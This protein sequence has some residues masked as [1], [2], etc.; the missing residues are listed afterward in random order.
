MTWTTK[1]IGLGACLAVLLSSAA[2]MATWAAPPRLLT[3]DGHSDLNGV[4][5]NA[6]IT[7]LNRP[8]N[9]PLV[10]T[11]EQAKT[12][13][14]TS[15]NVKRSQA[16]AKPSNL[17]P[18]LAPDRNTEQ[19]YNA[20][21][22]DPGMSMGR[23]KDEYRTSWIV[24]P[25]DGQ[26]PLTDKGR[27]QAKVGPARSRAA[28]AGPEAMA[29]NDRCLIGSRGSGGPGMLNNLYNNTYQI[30]QTPD[31][32]AIEV[33]M[34]HDVRIIPL[35]AS[36][37]LAQAGHRPAVMHPWLGDS[38]GWWE[39]AV[40]VVETTNVN[41]EQGENGPIFLSPQGLVTERFQRW[42]TG[43]IFYSFEVSDPL[44]YTGPWKAEMGL[45]AIPGQL[46]EYACHEGNYA[47]EGML[48]GAR[49]E[50]KLRAAKAP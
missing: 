39:G 28:P 23:V 40:L 10:L 44:Y 27:A 41:P 19:G 9:T 31:A 37:A 3:A 21:W 4:W 43:Q 1:T 26:L 12:M 20:G 34:V 46:Y 16:D 6:S 47:M 50:E 30:A 5:S 14:A 11:A 7:Q 13:A 22:L 33:E 48:A 8:A 15:G 18:T 25:A 29:P 2:P 32:I 24:S 38:V 42:S 45:T 36:K 17:D 35:F 49:A